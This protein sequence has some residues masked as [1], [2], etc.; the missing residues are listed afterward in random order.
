VKDG[1]MQV[2]PKTGTIR[3]REE[4]GDCQ[5]HVEWAEPKDIQGSSQGRGNSGVFLMGLIEIQVLDSYHNLTYADGGAG[6]IYGQSVPLANAVHPPGEWQ[7]Y[8]IVFRRP[9]YKN[10]KP[11]DPGYVTL[12]VNGVLAQDHFPLEGPTGHMRRAHPQPFPEKGPLALQD[13][14]NPIRFRNIWYRPLPPRPIEG[15]TDGYLTTEATIAKRKAIAADI[16]EDAAHLADPANP[17]PELLRLL[18]SLAYASD[19]ATLQKVTQLTHAYVQSVKQVPADKIGGKKD[20]VKHVKSAFDYLSKAKA[21][22]ADFVPKTE[23]EA[24]IKDQRW[25]GKR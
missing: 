23:V 1:V 5:L 19:E 4:F 10:G 7:V 11:V 2:V 17:V 16:R 13:H 20:E 8:D 12:F 6:S 22:P 24:L 18:E 14:G 3:T 9:I 21:L 15:G 25:D